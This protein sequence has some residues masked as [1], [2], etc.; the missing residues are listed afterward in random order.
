M[1]ER[2]RLPDRRDAELINF[3]CAGRRWTA[4]IGRFGDGRL[5][6]VF[7]HAPKDSPLLAMSQDAAILASIALQYGAPAGV[8]LHAL[9]GRDAGPL[10][11]AL[12]EIQEGRRERPRHS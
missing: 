10:A 1:S 9:A 12:A 6:E 11:A 3:E 2:E 5:A 4:T 8:I 7:L